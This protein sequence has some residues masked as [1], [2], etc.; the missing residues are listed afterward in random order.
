MNYIYKNVDYETILY[1]LLKFGYDENLKALNS[2]NVVLS[3][4]CDSTFEIFIDDFTKSTLEFA[5]M[6]SIIK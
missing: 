5:L 1:D 4:H 3:V 2:R 6:Q